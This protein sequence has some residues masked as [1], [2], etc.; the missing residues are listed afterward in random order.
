MKTA[1]RKAS[2]GRRYI[3]R[4]KSIHD[5]EI[6]GLPRLLFVPFD[7]VEP[8]QFGNPAE[9]RL[10]EIPDAR[11]CTVHCLYNREAKHFRSSNSG[12][13]IDLMLRVVRRCMYAHLFFLFLR[14]IRKKVHTLHSFHTPLCRCKLWRKVSLSIIYIVNC[15]LSNIYFFNSFTGSYNVLPSL[16]SAGKSEARW[17]TLIVRETR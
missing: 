6:F 13:N 15:K 4:T 12:I 3:T 16:F 17:T 10:L 2:N 1:W 5:N 7:N 11:V 14:S 8:V 9:R